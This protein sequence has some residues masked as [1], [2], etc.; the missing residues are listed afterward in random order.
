MARAFFRGFTGSS[1]IALG[2]I[3]VA[4]SFGL[5]AVHSGLSP[6]IAVLISV[7]V[8]A[9]ASQFVLVSL[10][11]SGSGPASVIGIVLLMNLRHFFYGPAM[12]EKLPPAMHRRFPVLAL[13]AGLTDEVFATSISKLTQQP[14]HERE[15]WYVGL[16]L[17]AYL[18][19]VAGTAVGAYFAYDWVRDYPL[20]SQMLTF[21][22]PALFFALLLEIRQLVPVDVIVGAAVT[23]LLSLFFFPSYVA[24]II[25]M[26]SGAL[27]AARRA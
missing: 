18:S 16:Q 13:A 7:L 27:L 10:V 9:G 21:V 26:L 22:L 4:I 17:G 12:L 23:T 3:P 25:G 11:S 15:R 1:S 8:Y 5:M 19:W 6:E 24:L 14:E 2:Y 20:V